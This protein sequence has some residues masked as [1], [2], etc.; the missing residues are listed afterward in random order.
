M[1]HD[2]RELISIFS[3]VGHCLPSNLASSSDLISMSLE[4]S[5]RIL[6]EMLTHPV[7]GHFRPLFLQSQLSH[8]G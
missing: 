2:P 3:G 1:R 8:I 4:L 7:A 6:T 5:F